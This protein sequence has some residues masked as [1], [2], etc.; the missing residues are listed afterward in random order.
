M[1][2]RPPRSTRTDTRFPCRTLIRSVSDARTDASSSQAV[3]PDKRAPLYFIGGARSGLHPWAGARPVHGSSR[4][5]ARMTGEGQI[6]R[7]HVWTPVTNAHLVC[8]VLLDKKNTDRIRRLQH[9]MNS[10][11]HSKT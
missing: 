9:T 1:I 5:G 8:R 11:Y 2:R 7:A 4:R 10:I 3:I 6:G